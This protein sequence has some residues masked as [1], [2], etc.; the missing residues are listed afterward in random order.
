MKCTIFTGDLLDAYD[1][2]NN[3]AKGKAL[4]KEVIIH[5]YVT[6]GV[7]DESETQITIFVFHPDDDHWNKTADKP[8]QPI[9]PE[10]PRSDGME[11]E[12]NLT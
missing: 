4:T 7:E 6:H 1:Q 5:T 10:T 9:Q 2:F 12:A 8:I 3:W 11:R